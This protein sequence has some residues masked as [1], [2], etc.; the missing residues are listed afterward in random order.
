MMLG[1]LKAG[2]AAAVFFVALVG[3]AWRAGLAAQGQ[4]RPGRAPR[5]SKAQAA[6]APSPERARAVEPAGTEETITYQGQVLDPDGKPLAGAALDLLNE[7]LE[8]PVRA[9]SG[10]DGRFRFEVPKSAFDRSF[11]NEPWAHATLVARAPGTGFGLANADKD[12]RELTLRLVRDDVPISGRVID[13]QGRPVAGAV[14]TVLGVGAAPDGRLDDYLKAVQERGE[15]GELEAKF[16]PLRLDGQPV[17]PVVPPVRTDADGRFRIAGIG[18]ER[19][20]ALQI[21]GPTIETKAVMARTRPGPAWRVPMRKEDEGPDPE[22]R[23]ERISFYGATFDHVAGPTRPI[24]GLVRDLDTGRPLAGIM[25]HGA[26]TPEAG[27][28]EN[29]QAITDAQGRYRLVGL[30]QGREGHVVAVPPL[31]FPY[32][33]YGRRKAALKLPPDETLPYLRTRVPVGKADGPGPV[34][35]DIKLRRGVWVTG[36]I[37][38]RDTRKPGAGAVEY[39]VFTDNPHVER[40]PGVAGTTMRDHHPAGT[41]GV[42]HLVAIPGPGLLTARVHGSQ[43]IR[44]AGAEALG[45]RVKNG[46]LEAYPYYAAPS[47]VNVIDLIDP[48][49]DSRSMTHDLLLETGRTLPVTV[50]GPDG[51]PLIPT[52]LVTV[53]LK[54]MI[55]W[56]NVPAGTTELRIVALA[57]GRDRTIGIRH[58]A[59]KLAGELALRGDETRPQTMTLRPWGVVTGRVVDADGQ[60]MGGGQVYPVALPAGYPKIGKAG[61]FRIE[62]FIPGKSYDLQILNG[63][64]LDQGFIALGLSV[65]PGETKDLGDVTPGKS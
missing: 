35:L 30:P 17:P 7:R 58:E 14:V 31:D 62:G 1:Q 49:P 60:P 11:S 6:P 9:T 42:F 34:H 12:S 51:R 48:A 54:D 26:E 29:V 22:D 47:N 18:R 57:P 5:M 33:Y 3:V 40:Y 4:A 65:G 19:V 32:P 61:R 64:G 8:H 36:R 46:Q 59:K 43:Y 15:L 28:A 52:E 38:D 44:A 16:L 55:W 20:A 27:S 13:L 63:A 50:L 53:G 2:A 39:F 45:D 24:E 41:D 10:A 23:P 56:E 37:L 25:V 21:E